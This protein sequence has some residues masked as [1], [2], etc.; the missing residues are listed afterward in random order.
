M[1]EGLGGWYSSEVLAKAV[2]ST[3]L[4]RRGRVEHLMRLTPLRVN[5]QAV[6]ASIGAVVN[7]R[8]V[9]W[10]ALRWV[11]N[12]V[13]LLDGQEP[14]PVPLTWPQ[15]LTLIREHPDAYPIEE[16]PDIA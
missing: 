9:H 6:R 16:A 12:T 3:P 15:Y 14:G 2:T 11:H 5:P 1:H 7:I 10:V 8:N 4:M 13:W